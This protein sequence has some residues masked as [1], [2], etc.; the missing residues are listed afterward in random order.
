MDGKLSV[1]LPSRALKLIVPVVIC[2]SCGGKE[3][4]HLKSLNFS[5]PSFPCHA[6]KLYN[7]RRNP[8]LMWPCQDVLADRKP[9]LTG[10]EP[11]PAVVT[12][13]GLSRLL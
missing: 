1:F 3:E 10:H 8:T 6:V 9:S 13:G 5:R 4:K 12:H 2:S 11:V 7:I